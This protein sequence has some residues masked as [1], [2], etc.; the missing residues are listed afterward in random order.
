MR[1][2]ERTR[3][4]AG[5]CKKCNRAKNPFSTA[6]CDYHLEYFR[7]RKPPKN[8]R[9][10]PNLKRC[11]ITREEVFRMRAAT[12]SLINSIDDCKK[13]GLHINDIRKLIRNSIGPIYLK[14]RAN[15]S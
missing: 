9:R 10:E 6:Y 5:L 14:R 15:E 7:N 8:G 1:P 3:S 11:G 12:H 4:A 13:A 2:N